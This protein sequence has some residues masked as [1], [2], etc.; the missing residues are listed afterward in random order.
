M[1]SRTAATLK[2]W[3]YSDGTT[4]YLAR[5]ASAKENSTRGALGTH[6]WFMANGKDALREDCVGPSA[7]WK[8]QGTCVRIWRLLIAGMLFVHVLPEGQV[9]NRW[10]FARIIGQCFPT[11]IRKARVAVPNHSWCKTTNAHCGATSLAR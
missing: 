3:V 10:E 11:W 2:R 9:M 7:Y 1:L 6:V 8:A 5:D 4:F